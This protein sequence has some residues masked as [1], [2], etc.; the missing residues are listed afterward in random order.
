MT[1]EELDGY[2]Q[3]T[4]SENDGLDCFDDLLRLRDWAR[5]NPN[6]AFVVLRDKDFDV[7][8]DLFKDYKSVNNNVEQS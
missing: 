7:F 8:L 1:T 4:I 3:E 2:V 5:S 6:C